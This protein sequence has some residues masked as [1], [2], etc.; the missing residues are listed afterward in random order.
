[1]TEGQRLAIVRRTGLVLLLIAGGIAVWLSGVAHEVFFRR[2][3][4]LG[5]ALPEPSLWARWLSG[6]IWQTRVA[7]LL[8]A[9]GVI[10]A[11]G[12]WGRA[13][14]L[15]VTLTWRDA[16][17]VLFLFVSLLVVGFCAPLL[18]ILTGLQTA[19]G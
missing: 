7:L 11:E 5:I 9:A 12:R 19:A 18:T 8:P 16:G 3:D 13:R 4:A 2:M 6:W 1:M 10:V 17:V 14:P 15:A